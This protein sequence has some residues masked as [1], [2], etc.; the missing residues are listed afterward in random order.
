MES[1][2]YRTRGHQLWLPVVEGPWLSG[3]TR[4][5]AP[6]PAADR[7]VILAAMWLSLPFREAPS[8]QAPSA[9]F[10]TGSKQ[11]G[12]HLLLGVGCPVLLRRDPREWAG[13]K[14]V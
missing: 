8:L 12:G 13:R 7:Q 9:R 4:G 14:P 3:S 6:G 10:Q 11:V 2:G 5:N 1:T